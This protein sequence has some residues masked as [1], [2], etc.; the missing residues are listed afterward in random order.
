MTDREFVE[1][2]ESLTFPAD[3]FHHREHVWLAWVY[4]RDLPLLDALT[5]FSTSLQRFAAHLGASGKYHETITFAFLFLI[6]QRMQLAPAATFDEFAAVN[7]DL[8]SWQPS[9][10]DRYYRAE[11]LQSELARRTFVL[12]DQSTPISSTNRLSSP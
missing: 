5:R 2:F 11:T 12:P 8:F 1:A 4:L 3:D 6:H 9:I 7:A 10:L